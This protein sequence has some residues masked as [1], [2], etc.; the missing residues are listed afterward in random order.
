MLIGPYYL[1]LSYI[2][3]A[4]C[5]GMTAFHLAMNSYVTETTPTKLRSLRFMTMEL[6]IFV[7]K[8]NNQIMRLDNQEISYLFYHTKSIFYTS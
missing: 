2:P 7:G 3:S 1:I 6:F 8:S 5:G 4:V